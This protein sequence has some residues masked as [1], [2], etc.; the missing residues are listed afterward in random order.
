MVT[1]NKTKKSGKSSRFI[2]L[3]FTLIGLSFV[4]V[5][6]AITY[7]T[8]GFMENSIST[9][10]QV[11]GVAANTSEGSTT[12]QPTFGYVD[13]DGQL[14][15][16]TTSLSASGYNFAIGKKME[17]LYDSRDFSEVRLNTW[18][19]TWGF[20]VIFLAAGIVPLLIGQFIRKLGKS[21]PRRAGVD[22]R[23]HKAVRDKYV[24]LES[25]ESDEDHQR[26]T[27][28]KPTVRR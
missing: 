11:L 8:Y 18:F 12:Y 21:P 16:G 13:T 19:S 26:E 9:T 3:I 14:Q 23:R 22:T 10:G 24:R 17:I 4:V 27:N 7:A 6:G 15:Q 1:F 2:G 5:G 20:G 25:P 28:Y